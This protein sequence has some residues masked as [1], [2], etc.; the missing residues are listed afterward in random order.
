MDTVGRDRGLWCVVIERM[1][2]NLGHC[3]ATALLACEASKRS[4]RLLKVKLAWIYSADPTVTISH[5]DVVPF[6]DERK[7]V[8]ALEW[9][10]PEGEQVRLP[11][12]SPL[13][14]I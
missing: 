11:M 6:E 8:T 1:P 10:E 13:L 12:I 14:G 4:I 2:L 9:I 5:A 7:S 3:I